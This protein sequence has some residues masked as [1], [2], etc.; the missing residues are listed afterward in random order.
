[1]TSPRR[2]QDALRRASPVEARPARITAAPSATGAQGLRGHPKGT[3]M[4]RRTAGLPLTLVAGLVASRSADAGNRK[5]CKRPEYRRAIVGAGLVLRPMA[6]E[7]SQI[8]QDALSDVPDD[9][10]RSL[11]DIVM[12]PARAARLGEARIAELPRRHRRA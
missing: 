9:A 12:G 11:R 7:Q 10:S 2:P 6:D 1:M 3:L 8:R 5:R 4:K